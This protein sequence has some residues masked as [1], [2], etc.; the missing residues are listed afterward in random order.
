MTNGLGF[1][2][3]IA[4]RQPFC[5]IEATEGD[6]WRSPVTSRN[7]RMKAQRRMQQRIRMVVEE[8]RMSRPGDDLTDPDTTVELPARVIGRARMDPS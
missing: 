2:K 5:Q 3:S 8:R 1:G 6:P 7:E 4:T